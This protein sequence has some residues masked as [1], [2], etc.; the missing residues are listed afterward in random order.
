MMDETLKSVEA[1]KGLPREDQFVWT[2]PGWPMKHIL[3]NTTTDRL[4]KVRSALA[5]GRFKVH[6]LPFT[7]ETESSDMETLVRSMNFSSQINRE[8]GFPL[9]RGAKLTDVPSHSWFLPTMLTHAGVKFL[10]IG[11]NGGSTSPNL[12]TVFWWEGPDGSRLLTL[13]WAQYYGSGILPPKDWPYK[14]WLAM[15]HTHENTGAPKPEEVAAVLK[16]AREKM[17]QARVKIGQ[18]EDFY[19]ALMSEKAD[20]PVVRGDLPD[21]WIHGYMSMPREVKIN[22]SVQRTIYN[23]E[24]LNTQLQGWN[25]S[26]ETIEPYVDKA[27]E[28]SLLFDE[29]SFGIALSHGQL[30]TWNFDE[31]FDAERAAGNYDFAEESWYEKGYHTHRARQ[32]ITPS[33]RKDLTHLAQAVSGDGKKVVVYNPLPWTRSGKVNM[34]MEVYMK[35]FT[36]YALKDD[37]TGKI[38]PAYNNSNQLTFMATDVPSMGYK[39]YTVVTEQLSEDNSSLFMDKQANI[40]ENEYF[41][42]TISPENGSLSSVWDKRRN[43]EMVNKDSEFGFGEYIHERYGK[44]E[45]KRYCDNYVKPDAH[46]WADQEMCRPLDSE[47]S[48]QLNRGK[49]KEIAFS[50]HSNA[51][52]ATAYCQSE[53]GEDYTMTYTLNE[54]SPYI[55]LCW[56]ISNKKASMHPE[57]GWIAFPFMVNKPEFHLGRLGAVV[58]PAKDL[59][60]NS[61]HDYY[62]VNTG[63]ALSDKKTSCDFGLNTPDAP[64]ISLD[65][66]GLHRFDG[67][68][69]PKHPNVFVNVFNTQWGTNFTEYIDGA[70]S[71]RMYLWSI[72]EYDNESSLITPTEETRVP[73]IGVYRDGR[74]GSLASTSQGISLSRK[75]VLVTAYGKNRDGEGHILRLWEQAGKSGQC[76]IG[77]PTNEYHTAQLCNLRGEVIGKPFTIKKQK[78]SVDMKA[79]EPVSIILK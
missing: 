3:E 58:N 60:R 5:N 45:M 62:F 56:G 11:C 38:I 67:D 22:K 53:M 28:Q 18:L 59:V 65:R 29:H 36:V 26:T 51:I 47:L 78:L 52:S 7:F 27:I 34:F 71:A 77:L 30:G 32:L 13:N 68:F 57:G 24:A 43:R 6:A 40:L 44:E 48:Y 23:E 19:D 39:T 79:Y 1:T 21:T 4:P 73:L 2:L 25:V 54:N 69:I 72:D 10:H 37:V 75:G 66:T 31:T 20:I 35:D 55:E 17:P 50:R 41:R 49:V 42:L 33:L 76:E 12:P 14:T 70:L 63:L 46:G 61:N 64:G 9:P 15:I 8:F 16:T 74:V